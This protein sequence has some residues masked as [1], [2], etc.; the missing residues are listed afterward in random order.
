[1]LSV[2]V[3]S[4]LFETPFSYIYSERHNLEQEADQ[5]SRLRLRTVG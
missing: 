5:R 2:P 4:E 3:A 1:M